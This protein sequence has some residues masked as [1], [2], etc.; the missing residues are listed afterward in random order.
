MTTITGTSRPAA[1]ALYSCLWHGVGTQCPRLP[2]SRHSAG[3][4][5]WRS[6]RSGTHPHYMFCK[7]YP[8]SSSVTWSNSPP[9]GDQWHSTYHLPATWGVLVLWAVQCD[10]IYQMT[11][12]TLMLYYTLLFISC[13]RKT[14]CLI[15]YFF[16]G[17][18]DGLQQSS[19]HDSQ[20][21]AKTNRGAC[22]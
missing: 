4:E 5:S 9:G 13:C 6:P 10:E 14:H 20:T 8:A 22:S 17:L 19:R 2:C 11:T 15:Q 7:V 12:L 3:G 21:P 16:I 1:A 18:D